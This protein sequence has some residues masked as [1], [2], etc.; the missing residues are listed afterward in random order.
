MNVWVI[1]NGESRRNFALNQIKDH[2]IGCNAVHRDYSCTEF[3]AVDRRMVNEILRNEATQGRSVW[4]RPDWT[5]E[6]SLPRIKTL[7]DPPFT[8]TLKADIPFHW[9]SGP[10][11]VLL[12]TAYN[13]RQ[14]HLLG[15]DLYHTNNKVNN[16]YKDTENYNRS[17][18]RPVPPDFW[19]Y[20]LKKIFNY[21][22]RIDFIQHQQSDWQI[23]TEWK[24]IKNLTISYDIV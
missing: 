11:A 15:F 12:A 7:P 9:N 10:Y 22:N 19:I 20:Q 5:K 23:P 8:G 3:V 17:D 21:F 4:T 16:L 18:T 2:T 24:D 6:Y 1:G 14:I 13:P